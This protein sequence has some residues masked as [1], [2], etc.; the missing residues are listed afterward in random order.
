[1]TRNDRNTTRSVNQR[2]GN[3]GRKRA[4]TRTD[5]F[6]AYAMDRLLHR[7]GRSPQATEFFLKGGVLVA[8]LVAEPHRFTR[9]VDVL[10]RHGPP[11]PDDLRARFE[12][13]VAVTVDDGITW[14]RVRAIPTDRAVDDY[15]GVKVFVEASVE[16]HT[17]EV[18]IDI[19]FGDAVE[20]DAERV[21]L[22]PFLDGDPPAV[23]RAYRAESVVAE[24]VQTLLKRFPLIEH[25]LKDLLDVVVLAE[26]LEF[27]GPTLTR[28][29]QVTFERRDTRPEPR[30]LDDLAAEMSGKRAKKWRQDWQTMVKEKAASN[31]PTLDE[32]VH[33]FDAFVRP[34]LRAL[35]L[36]EVLAARWPRR[37]PWSP[38]EAAAPS[39]CREPR[40]T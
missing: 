24:K 15:D 33:R 38:R 26:R 20:P 17:V 13:I 1:M 27:D 16:G 2:V 3:E 18:R 39:L 4:L 14:G 40:H 5:A 12:S 34:V 9:D 23:V 8:N 22:A 32:A 25:R 21:E 36:R 35:A 7:L 28:S 31:A 6:T 11:E 30:V 19:G 29:M 37:G 10:R